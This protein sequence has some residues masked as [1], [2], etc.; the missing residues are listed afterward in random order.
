M[1]LRGMD[2][3]AAVSD[4]LWMTLPPLP[5]RGR[6]EVATHGRAVLLLLGGWVLSGEWYPI[7]GPTQNQHFCNGQLLL[8]PSTPYEV[9]LVHDFSHTMQKNLHSDLHSVH[10]LAKHI[11]TQIDAEKENKTYK[12][13]ICNLQQPRYYAAMF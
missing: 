5:T 8:S 2:A 10:F 1:I 6:A 13:A 12:P 9:P 3:M 7:P 11:Q 4:I